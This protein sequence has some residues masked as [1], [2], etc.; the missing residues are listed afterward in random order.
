MITD[1]SATPASVSIPGGTLHMS[2][3]PFKKNSAPP[4]RKSAPPPAA[5]DWS[6]G[7]AAAAEDAASKAAPAAREPETEATGFSLFKKTKTKAQRSAPPPRPSPE[8]KSLNSSW[9]EDGFFGLH[10]PEL[11]DLGDLLEFG[12]KTEIKLRK[13]ESSRMDAGAIDDDG[14]WLL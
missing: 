11:P 12:N 1:S 10:M 2:G 14:A 4:L 3:K 13:L 8:P 7:V 9:E 5:F 6:F